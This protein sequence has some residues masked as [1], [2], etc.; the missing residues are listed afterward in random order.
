[1]NRLFLLFSI[2]L[3]GLVFQSCF[4]HSDVVQVDPT[5]AKSELC[6]ECHIHE[7]KEWQK[8]AHSRAFTSIEFKRQTDRY[9]IKKCLSCH[10]P[11]PI[12]GKKKVT[13]RE[14]HLNEGVNCVACHLTPD[15][16]MGGPLFVLPAHSVSMNDEYYLKSELCGTCHEEHFEQWDKF[17]PPDSQAKQTCQGCHM[18]SAERK[19]ITEGLFQYA[20]WKQ[21]VRKHLFLSEPE[22]QGELKDWLKVKAETLSIEKG[23]HPIRVE[24]NHRLPHAFPAG[25][26]GFKAIDLLVSIKS[27]YGLTLEEQIT[28][29][30]AEEKKN[31]MPNKTYFKIFQFKKADWNKAEYIEIRINRR[32][33]RTDY[34]VNL[35]TM[36]RRI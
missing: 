18:P 34:G 11:E 36:H 32:K 14:N 31:I 15:Q 6:G 30:Y 29:L 26:F 21:D 3:I 2:G 19:L 9:K 25:I 33:S 7:Y 28:T 10:I 23:N 16:K 27:E 5:T 12:Y 1:M 13:A 35:L 17:E 8:S 24:L 20:H 4:I 22:L